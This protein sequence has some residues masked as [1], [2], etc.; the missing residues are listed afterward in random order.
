MSIASVAAQQNGVS[1]SGPTA[2]KSGTSSPG[3]A[4]TT[5]ASTGTNGLAALS[6]NYNDFLSLLTTQLKNQ[7]PSSPLDAN[8]FTTEL[9]QFSQVEQQINTNQSLSQL[10]QLT[11]AGDVLQSSSLLGKHVNV[12]ASQLALQNGSAELQFSA[13]AGQQADISIYNSS[14][15]KIAEQVITAQNGTNT[16]T[17]NGQDANGNT[18]PDGAYKVAVQSITGQGAG[19]GAALPF[20]VVGTATGVQNSNGNVQVS[21]GALSVPFSAI[22]SVGN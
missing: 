14:G 7:D 6:N 20:T 21:L 17:W 22:A 18:Q 16:W 19:A 12:T 1:T 9:V 11:Q 8:Q 15:T 3:A 2:T 5:A 10:I 4:S 13:T